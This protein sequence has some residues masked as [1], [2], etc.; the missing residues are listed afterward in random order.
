MK[1]FAIL[2]ASVALLGLSAC[3]GST[4]EA[5]PSGDSTTVVQSD[6]LPVPNATVTNTTVIDRTRDQGDS[7]TIDSKG[8]RAT[9]G[10]GGTTVTTDINKNPSVTVH[11]N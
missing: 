3:G 6:T 4:T 10:D 1:K 8:V 9:V 11:E 5:T 7:V 2:S